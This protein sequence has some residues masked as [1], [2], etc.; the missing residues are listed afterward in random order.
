VTAH[1][2]V[3]GVDCDR[4][5]NNTSLF[6]LEQSALSR[7]SSLPWELRHYI[8]TFC[9]QGS[10]DNEVVVRHSME[11]GPSLLVRQSTGPH[12]YLWVNDP[13]LQWLEPHRIGVT[14][15]RELLETY[16]RIRTF[17]FIHDELGTLRP[18]L[19]TGTSNL[20]MRPADH[21]RRLHLQIQPFRYAQLRDPNAKHQEEGTCRKAL[22]SLLD[23]HSP[24]TAIEIHADLAQGFC[25]DEEYNK[26]LEDAAG[27]TFRTIGLVDRLKKSGLN[28]EFF[29][30]GK[31]DGRDGTTICSGSLPSL[32]D[33][34]TSMKVACQ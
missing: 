34:I 4:N 28:V 19:E 15:A 25:D 24:R 9:V 2:V 6:L 13:I 22:E 3:L 30:Q 31:W 11:G 18:F 23:L 21:V 26:L 17:K 20:A 5:E 32:N 10:Y 12:S 33:C 14:A 1:R 8:H 7:Y 29:F 16:Y 27:F